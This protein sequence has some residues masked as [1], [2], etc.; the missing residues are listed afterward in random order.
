MISIRHV[1]GAAMSLTL[2]CSSAP[3]SSDRIMSNPTSMMRRIDSEPETAPP[4][5]RDA[6]PPRRSM[7]EAVRDALTRVAALLKP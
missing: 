2:S 3:G 1:V 4:S 7:T 5:I 6:V